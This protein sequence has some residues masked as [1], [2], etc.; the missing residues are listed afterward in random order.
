MP[1]AFLRQPGYTVNLIVEPGLGNR[2]TADTATE[3]YMVGAANRFRKL[4]GQRIDRYEKLHG[5]AI[6]VPNVQTEYTPGEQESVL[7]YLVTPNT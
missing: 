2:R 5:S 3:R 6:Q 7:I 1:S 4:H